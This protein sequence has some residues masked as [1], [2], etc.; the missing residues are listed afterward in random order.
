MTAHTI[1]SRDSIM[2]H[3]RNLETGAEPDGFDAPGKYERAADIPLAFA[4][5]LIWLHGF[6]D[7]DYGDVDTAPNG[8]I[9]LIGRWIL[10]TDSQGFVTYDEYPTDQDAE[11][12]FDAEVEAGV[13]GGDE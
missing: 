3:A 9:A 5:D 8:H 6:A 7:M 10:R 4:L 11:A 13:W 1:T 2:H 12:A